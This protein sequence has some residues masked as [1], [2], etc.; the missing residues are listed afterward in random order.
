MKKIFSTALAAFLTMLSLSSCSAP[1][2]DEAK[3]E[4]VG[5][6]PAT[7]K[8][9]TAVITVEAPDTQSP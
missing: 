7:S 1:A 4:P 3:T 2:S 5:T 8:Q 6:S 9:T